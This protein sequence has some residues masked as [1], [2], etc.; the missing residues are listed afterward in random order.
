MNERVIRLIKKYLPKVEFVLVTVIVASL[1][2]SGIDSPGPLVSISIIIL[3]MLYF[4]SAYIPPEE[5]G[6]LFLAIVAPKVLGIGWTICT[7]GI[8]FHLLRLPGAPSTLGI[9]AT[10]VAV[11]LLIQIIFQIKF[12]TFKLDLPLLRSILLLAIAGFLIS[13]NSPAI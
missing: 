10:S 11:A 7:V 4:M 8:L 6:S 13:P 2:L 9:G 1:L 3:A 5:P 12:D